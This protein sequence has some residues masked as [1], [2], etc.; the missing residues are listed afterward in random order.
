MS[1]WAQPRP[2]IAGAGDL[3]VPGFTAIRLAK[4]Y[5]EGVLAMLLSRPDQQK[6]ALGRIVEV[7]FAACRREEMAL[8]GLLPVHG[9]GAFWAFQPIEGPRALTVRRGR[10]EHPPSCLAY[11]VQPS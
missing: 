10:P 6:K 7:K 9:E 4:A 2:Q 11:R 3:I 5:L 8:G 1:R